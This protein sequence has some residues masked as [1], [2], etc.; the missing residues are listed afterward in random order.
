VDKKTPATGKPDTGG[1]PEPETHRLDLKFLFSDASLRFAHERGM[2]ASRR[3]SP[4][5]GAALQ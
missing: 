4:A 2:T 3:G 5:A 1:C